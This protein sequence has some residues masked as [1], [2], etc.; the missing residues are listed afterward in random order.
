MTKPSKHSKGPRIFHN[1]EDYTVILGPDDTTDRPLAEVNSGKTADARLIAAAPELLSA[2]KL[3]AKHI[4][5]VCSET[6]KEDLPE[7]FADL[8]A[9]N[10]AIAKAEGRS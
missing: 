8:K 10:A 5:H 7:W 9:I 2:L 1:G 4:D 3:A 6:S